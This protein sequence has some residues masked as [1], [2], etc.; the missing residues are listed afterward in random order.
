L[1]N[2]NGALSDS[3]QFR[4]GVTMW[5][6][7]L[8]RRILVARLLPPRRPVLNHGLAGRGRS[9]QRVGS[10]IPSMARSDGNDLNSQRQSGLKTTCPPPSAG[11]WK[12]WIL[13][14]KRYTVDTLK[15]E[16]G[17]LLTAIL[18]WAQ[19]S[20]ATRDRPQGLSGLPHKNLWQRPNSCLSPQPNVGWGSLLGFNSVVSSWETAHGWYFICITRYALHGKLI[21]ESSSACRK[22]RFMGGGYDNFQ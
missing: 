10:S 5:A 11:G 13:L 7:P 8:K 4:A 21:M 3:P 14:R 6:L 9:R 15:G 19:T 2:R 17:Q 18:L 22:K 12:S 1:Y 16:N 20:P